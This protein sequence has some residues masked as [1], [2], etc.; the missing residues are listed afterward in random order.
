[1]NDPKKVVTP[2]QPEPATIPPETPDVIMPTVVNPL[3]ARVYM[4][5]DTFTLPSGGIFYKNNEL[6]PEVTNGEVHVHPMAAYDDILLRTPDLLFSGQAV[7]KIFKRCIPQILKPMELFARDVD[8]LMACLK[9]ITYGDDFIFMY[10]HDCE[11]AKENEYKSNLSVFVKNAKRI[12]P[13][14]IGSL[15]TTVIESGQSV[16]MQPT[17]FKD[18]IKMLQD[19][20]PKEEYSAEEETD[21]IIDTIASVID[22]VDDIT[23]KEQIREWLQT[24]SAGWIGGLSNAIEKTSAWGP[25]FTHKTECKDCKE[26]INIQ[27]PVNPLSLFM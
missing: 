20:N 27:V 14:T 8:F 3:L 2:Q 21:N 26:E 17:R 22:S 23:N 24:I 16:K 13:T 1:M 9:K 6:A 7:E 15:Y 25:D 4:P 19:I 18:I 10:T 12:D 5:G 11:N